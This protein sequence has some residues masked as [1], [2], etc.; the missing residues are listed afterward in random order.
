MRFSSL[1]YPLII[2][3]AL[4]FRQTGPPSTTS[5][6]PCYDYLLIATILG[7]FQSHA[8]SAVSILFFAAIFVCA[9]TPQPHPPRFGRPERHAA[10][11]CPSHPSAPEPPKVNPDDPV[12]TIKGYLPDSSLQ[13]D[14]CKTMI[15]KA[16][17]KKSPTTSA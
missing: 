16:D 2:A 14:A 10:S 3:S 13:G 11:G 12:I 9:Q 8:S 5:R 4:G 15:T 7:G 1:A 6:P 17:S